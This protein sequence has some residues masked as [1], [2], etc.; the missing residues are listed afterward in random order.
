MKVEK[1]KYRELIFGY[2]NK[3]ES[4][5]RLCQIYTICKRFFEAENR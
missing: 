5:K 2:I 3:I 1:F 4:A